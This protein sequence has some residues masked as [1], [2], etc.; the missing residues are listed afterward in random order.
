MK[1]VTEF[2]ASKTIYSGVVRRQEAAGSRRFWQK[3]R[4]G[5]DNTVTEGFVWISADLFH[6][7]DSKQWPR[8]I[9]QAGS[10]LDRVFVRKEKDFEL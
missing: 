10:V 7:L 4:A 8:M 1:A 6:V 9:W 3:I 2:F 5:N